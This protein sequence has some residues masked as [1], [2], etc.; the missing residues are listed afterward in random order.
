M[1]PEER[2]EAHEQWLQDLDHAITKHNL[3]IADHNVGMA[4]HTLAM[5]EIRAGLAEIKN[6]QRDQAQAQA[7]QS[8]VLLELTQHVVRLLERWEDN[9]NK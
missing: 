1:T 8:A 7:K 6:I 3:A 5:A 9:G 4:N 2:F